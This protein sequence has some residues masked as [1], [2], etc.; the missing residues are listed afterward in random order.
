MSKKGSSRPGLFGTINHYDEDGKKT[1]HSR[2]GLFGGYS[3]YDEEGKKTGYSNKGL[4]GGYNHYD[5]DGNRTGRSNESFWGGYSHRNKDGKS[6]GTSTPGLFGSYS[7]NDE[8]GCYIA[9]CVYGSY[10]C[11]EVWTLRRFRDNILSQNIFGRLFISVYYKVSPSIVKWFGKT[12]W[13]HKIW[14]PILNK[15]IKS[16]NSKGVKNTPYKD[17]K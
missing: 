17:K 13:F 14:K 4:F 16:L 15:M 1:G 12:N 9:T 10:D 3:H 6:T 11:K 8:Q 2:P 5:N 7:H